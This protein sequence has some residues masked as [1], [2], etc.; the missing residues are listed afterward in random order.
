MNAGSACG[1]VF[2]FL[3]NLWSLQTCLK[4]CN[5]TELHSLIPAN[6]VRRPFKL[7]YMV[8]QIICAFWQILI[9]DLKPSVFNNIFYDY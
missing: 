5:P 6:V 4:A 7:L 2:F 3:L 8:T 1:E 9:L